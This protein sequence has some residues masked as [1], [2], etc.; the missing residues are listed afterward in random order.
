M[1][2]V[3]SFNPLLCGE[4]E[5]IVKFWHSPAERGSR[6]EPSVDESFDIISLEANTYN[7]KLNY[8]VLTDISFLHI[9]E[10]KII[11]AIRKYK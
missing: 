8:D 6:D 1:W 7:E 4:I 2:R 9:Q 10:S 11:E 3:C 5:C